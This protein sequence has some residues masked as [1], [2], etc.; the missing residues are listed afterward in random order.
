MPTNGIN[1]FGQPAHRV[2]IHIESPL[3][4]FL[5][6][7]NSGERRTVH[8]YVGPKFGYCNVDRAP[9]SD[10]L[11]F[12]ITSDHFI[13]S[14]TC[15]LHDLTSKLTVGTG[16]NDFH[17][18]IFIVEPTLGRSQTGSCFEG[19]PPGSMGAVPG[20]GFGQRLLE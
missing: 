14:G 1:C 9:V 8:Q 5:T 15:E 19:L 13:V 10:I 17:S 16:D 12:R 18:E 6:G 7:I 3:F 11:S 2:S 20:H 4:I